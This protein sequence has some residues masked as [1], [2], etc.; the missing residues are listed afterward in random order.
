MPDVLVA[1]SARDLTRAYMI[2][3][4]DARDYPTLSWTSKVPADR[5][6]R[7]FTIEDLNS[8]NEHGVFAEAQLLQIRAYDLDGRR[9]IQTARLIKGLWLAMPNELEVQSVD[10][11]GGPTPQVDPDVPG[12]ER[13]LITAWVTV[14]TA[15]A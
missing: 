15:P 5:P 11:I 14:V 10:V 13:L 2:S 6:E 9:C 3:E 1:P 8:V 7:F 4:L 12:L